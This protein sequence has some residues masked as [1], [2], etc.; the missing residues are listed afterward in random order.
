MQNLSVCR[1]AW[2]GVV[3][4][5]AGADATAATDEADH[6]RAAELIGKWNCSGISVEFRK[7]GTYTAEKESS[8]T[9]AQWNIKNGKLVI[10]REGLF[11]GKISTIVDYE[12]T[13]KRIV[14]PKGK[15][16]QVC[17]LS[18]QSVADWPSGQE[19]EAK[20]QAEEAQKQA[21]EAEKRALDR[22]IQRLEVESAMRE[23]E[24]N[25][26]LETKALAEKKEKLKEG[27][28][29]LKRLQQEIS[30][31]ER[32]PAR[33][34]KTVACVACAAGVASMAGEVGV[35]E[36]KL[37]SYRYELAQLKDKRSELKD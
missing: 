5:V 33:G 34:V 8:S 15:G 16:Q 26:D 12:I 7:D 36:G 28:E 6:R 37:K 1:S 3:L 17:P 20:R 14:F 27:E 10:V 2:I 31:M 19:A 24:R 13:G 30:R 18:L 25:I 32:G 35:S 11:G 9:K 22:K 23:C 29:V 4:V 21:A